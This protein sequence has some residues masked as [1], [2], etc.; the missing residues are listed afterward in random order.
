MGYLYPGQEFR[1]K[2]C[3]HCLTVFTPASPAQLFCGKDCA[4]TGK[5][6]QYLQRNYSITAGEYSARLYQ[7]DNRC[8]IC[9][10]EGFL[11]AGHHQF[12]LVVD[13]CHTTGEVRGLLCHNCNR[14]LGLL[15]DDT[16]VLTRAIDYL[17]GTR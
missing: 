16:E 8:K 2:A 3:K 12:K 4:A 13:H 9:K 7:Q 17:K 11:M 14:A 6:S 10:G 5:R 1:Q 15:K